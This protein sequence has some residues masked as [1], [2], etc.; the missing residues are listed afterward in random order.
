MTRLGNYVKSLVLSYTMAYMEQ[1]RRDELFRKAFF[2]TIVFNAIVGLADLVIGLLFY[3]LP[4]VTVFMHEST[5]P[6]AT[7]L[8]T[9][10]LIISGQDRMMGM[11][12]FF[13]HG[14]VKLILAWGLILRK[15]WAYP[16]AII[17]LTGFTVY[18]LL[19]ILQHFTFFT[20]LL[21]AVN[22]ATIYF[23]SREYR[24]VRSRVY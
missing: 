15:L 12:Y 3:F 21:M 6:V 9:V 22:A 23:I 11:V 10:F 4:E 13:S 8:K 14:V 7:S 1:S 18:Q 20:L 2:A 24:Q 16:F 19:E 17:L 5:H